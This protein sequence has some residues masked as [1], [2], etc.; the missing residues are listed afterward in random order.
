MKRFKAN[1]ESLMSNFHRVS[2]AMACLRLC[3]IT[4]ESTK[5]EKLLIK[6]K[7]RVALAVELSICCFCNN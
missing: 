6:F 1:G 4:N 7:Q 5:T 3:R 2:F